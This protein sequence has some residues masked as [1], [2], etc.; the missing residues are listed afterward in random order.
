MELEDFK[1]LGIFL[2][3]NAFGVVGT[4]V[5][6]EIVFFVIDITKV[7]A[8]ELVADTLREL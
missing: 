5:F 4:L 3:L 6:V 8:E 7:V 1:L 2:E